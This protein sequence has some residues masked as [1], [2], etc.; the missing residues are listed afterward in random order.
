MARAYICLTRNDLD[1]SSLQALDLQ[2]NASQ[3]NAI[4]DPQ[5]QSCYVTAAVQNDVVVTTGAGPI[6]TNADYY[7]LAAYLVDSIEVAAAGA[8]MTAGNSTTI[9]AAILTALCAGSAMTSAAIN[10]I[11][12]V[13]CANSGIGIGTSTAT[14]EDIL[15][16]LSGL[17]FKLPSGSAVE[18]A[19]NL[20]VPT[21]S[22]YFVTAPNVRKGSTLR[23]RAS[24]S[25]FTATGATQT[26]TQ[27][28]LYRNLRVLVDTGDLHRSCDSG[29][30]SKLKATTY[31]FRNPSFIY[32]SASGT[33]KTVA[34]VKIDGPLNSNPYKARAVVVYA[35]DGTVI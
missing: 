17:V 22:G 6:T 2:P 13:T 7:G 34:N 33:A 29:V 30:L 8:A 15:K 26:G 31:S 9:A 35:A 1:E 11:I 19:G 23:G 16:I 14:V 5:P 4:Y 27:S 21:Q 10:A 20:F 28:T 25:A 24:G 12:H 32:S 3:R 18:D